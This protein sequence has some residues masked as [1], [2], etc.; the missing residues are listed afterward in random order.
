MIWKNKLCLEEQRSGKWSLKPSLKISGITTITSGMDSPLH[1][2]QSLCISSPFIWLLM[3][4]CSF[5]T[6][7]KATWSYCSFSLAPGSWCI[8]HMDSICLVNSSEEILALH[9]LLHFLQENSTWP[10]LA[11][12]IHALKCDIYSHAWT[13]VA[14]HFAVRGLKNVRVG[15][16]IFS[17]GNH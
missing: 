5:R 8:Q 12:L 15:F 14:A 9:F 13:S 1:G 10:L 16:L 17:W 4:L 3:I 7:E 6:V 2:C 11:M